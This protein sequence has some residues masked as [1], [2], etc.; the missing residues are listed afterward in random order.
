MW[1]ILARIGFVVALVWFCGRPLGLRWAPLG[2]FLSEGSCGGCCLPSRGSCFLGP[3]GVVPRALIMRVLAPLGGAD[4]RSSGRFGRDSAAVLRISDWGYFL[5]YSACFWAQLRL[6]RVLRGLC[7]GHCWRSW[8]VSVGPVLWGLCASALWGS[9][10]LG[11]T[12]GLK[13]PLVCSFGSGLFSVFFR[14]RVWP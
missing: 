8:V 4:V 3:L 2:A 12:S 1:L 9:G 11:F 14:L 6:L 5:R 10:V 13:G 7:S